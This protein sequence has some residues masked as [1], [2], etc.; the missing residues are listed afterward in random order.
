[1]LGTL[2]DSK[3]KFGDFPDAKLFL[4]I[5]VLSEIV[6]KK[7]FPCIALPFLVIITTNKLISIISNDMMD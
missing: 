2:Y 1:M 7:K 4:R 6:V 3:L 5:N